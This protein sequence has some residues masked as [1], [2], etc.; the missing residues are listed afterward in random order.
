VVPA[1]RFFHES[2]RGK[3]LIRL[4]LA[5]DPAIVDEGLRRIV[6]FVE[7]RSR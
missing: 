4:A 7:H 2:D 5:R 1:S 3:R 6:G